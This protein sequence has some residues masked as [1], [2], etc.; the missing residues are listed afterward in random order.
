MKK[1]RLLS[2]GLSFVLVFG[3]V[4]CNLNVPVI[5]SDTHKESVQEN[6][7][8]DYAES[9]TDAQDSD[10]S[11]VLLSKYQSLEDNY[12][13]YSSYSYDSP[14]VSCMDD[15]GIKGGTFD[16]FATNNL[17]GMAPAGAP[18]EEAAVADE[19][20]VDAMPAQ[21]LDNASDVDVYDVHYDDLE[22]FNTSE[23]TS[24]KDN[25]YVDALQNPLSTFAADVD[26]ASYCLF[27]QSMY[28]S[29]NMARFKK[30][31]CENEDDF[32]LKND[33]FKA[34]Y[35][36]SHYADFVFDDIRDSLR[37]E[38]FMNYF[39]YD[40][41]EPVD[42]EP[43]GVLTE[44][45][46]CPWNEDAKLLRVGVKAKTVDIKDI[47]SNIVLLV[48]TSGSMFSDN[49][50]PLAVNSIKALLKNFG[51][52]D[53]IS[54]VTYAG[55][56]EVLFEGLGTDDYRMIVRM[57]DE[58][59]ASGSTNGAAGITTAYD[60]ASKYYIEGGNNRV[61]LMTDGDFNVGVS[62]ESALVTLIKDYA[63]TNI[64]FSAC[65]FGTDTYS[66]TRMEALADNGNGNYDY[67]DCSYEADKFFT[68]EFETTIYTVAKDVKFQ[69]D[70]NPAKVVA[71]K[72]IGYVNRQLA[73][74]DFDNDSVDGG[75]VGSGDTV[76]ILY[77]I[78][79]ADS[80]HVGEYV[81]GGSKYTEITTTGDT[82]A[83]G[84]VKI[85]AK[86]P[87]SIG[88]EMYEYEIGLDCET[89][90]MSSDMKWAALVA[91]S[92]TAIRNHDSDRVL[93]VY[94][95]AVKNKD[96]IEDDNKVEFLYL[97]NLYNT[98]VSECKK[99]FE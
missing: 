89:E 41:N 42:N 77:E 26:T 94:N 2:L 7:T 70:F 38:E 67:I 57:L 69:I 19:S 78:I 9:E 58:L 14:F 18:A 36:D 82:S 15:M 3:C 73:D 60:L 29:H 79:P 28:D 56:D 50:L 17:M 16:M 71:Y 84:T 54:L 21:D 13:G 33:R 20:F 39:S 91:D 86:E 93:S 53:V 97:L 8:G 32:D 88:S 35:S 37:V 99:A 4:G 55:S 34:L 85:R 48:D 83:Y 1:L 49:K 44:V 47:K 40:Y 90:T 52:D 87:E 23:F 43:F 81:S 11:D 51:P 92:I 80:E 45:S 95:D 30:M 72:Q 31:Y 25:S 68:D 65:G 75:E 76:T 62:S 22:G 27:R 74:A 66:D 6:Q 10:F 24:V 96:M 61:I 63:D 12:D 98:C 46:D 5:D 64:F 59:E